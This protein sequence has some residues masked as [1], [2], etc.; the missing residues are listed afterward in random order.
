M[1]QTAESAKPEI[2]EGR[3]LSWNAEKEEGLVE[4]DGEAESALITGDVFRRAGASRPPTEGMQLTCVIGSK[5]EGL[6]VEKINELRLRRT[7]RTKRR[8]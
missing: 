1:N 7:A 6:V 8:A 3:L 4:L 2:K 5:P